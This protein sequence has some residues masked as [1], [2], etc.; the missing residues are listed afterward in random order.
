MLIIYLSSKKAASERSDEILIERRDSIS[1][2]VLLKYKRS[3]FDGFLFLLFSL[4]L[5]FS[6]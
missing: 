2:E 5:F 6:A 1:R 3:N 4:F